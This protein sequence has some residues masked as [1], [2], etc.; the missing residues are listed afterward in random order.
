MSEGGVAGPGAV[1]VRR[2]SSSSGCRSASGPVCRRPAARDGRRRAAPRRG[3]AGPGLANTPS[4]DSYHAL[5]DTVVG[6]AALHLD[7][8][9][10]HWAADGLLA[11]FFFVAGL[12]LKRE[13]VVGELRRL[14][15]ARRAGRRGPRRHG[16]AR[17]AL[18]P[19]R[20]D[21]RRRRRP[22]G[23][24]H[25]DGDRHR[26]RARRARGHRVAAAGG[27]A[28]VPAH[29]RRR[30]RPRR[31]HDHRG[32]LH[33]RLRAAVPV[34]RRV[35]GSASYWL[36]QQ[37]RVDSWL[38]LRPARARR[39]GADAR[40]RRARDRRRRRC[41][42]SLVPGARPEPAASSRLP[43]DAASST[44]RARSRRA[45]PCRCSRSSPRA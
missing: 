8:T 24:A 38:A 36:L 3:R 18:R 6:P 35:L 11:I 10:R 7:L 15:K 5:A 44:G 29:P 28:R 31:D 34:A 17:A 14:S 23:W 22:T 2:T 40:Q 39:L 21:R 32:V 26:L 13:L 9:L 30:R 1:A 45:S 41:S 27:A 42:G 20:R 16:R 4:R 37:R 19:R 43:A 12:E 33:P 25:P